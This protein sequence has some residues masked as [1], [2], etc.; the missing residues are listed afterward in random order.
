ML[1]SLAPYLAYAYLTFVGMTTRLR[2]YGNEHRLA[3]REKKQHFIYAFWHNRQVFF[4][5]THRDEGVSIMVS[6]SKDGEIIAKVMQ[7]SRLDASRGSSTRGASAAVRD[8]VAVIARGFDLGITPDGPKGPLFQVKPGV[9]FLAQKL[10][11]PILPLVNGMSHKLVFSRSW[12]KFQFPLP[13]G[14]AVVRYAAAIYVGPEDDLKTKAEE[15]R[16]S[17]NAITEQVDREVS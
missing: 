5:Y 16:L 3:L 10:G 15:L 12:D 6:Q 13:F 1:R 11:I 8:M 4:T 17:L 9:V 7:L 2:T 14:K